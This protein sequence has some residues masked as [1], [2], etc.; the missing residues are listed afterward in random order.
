MRPINDHAELSFGVIGLAI[1]VYA[2]VGIVRRRLVIFGQRNVYTGREAV[3]NGLFWMVF[4]LAFVAAAV[5]F[6]WGSA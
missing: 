4:G 6:Y 2:L 1:V 3:K 5:I